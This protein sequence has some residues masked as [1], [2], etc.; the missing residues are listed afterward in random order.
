MPVAPVAADEDAG[1]VVDPP[2]AAAV[3]DLLVYVVVL[4]LFIEYAPQ[5]LSESF[6]LSLLT[7]VLLKVVLEAVVAVKDR[8]KGRLRRASTVPARVVAALGLWLLLAGSKFV[9]LGAVNLVFGDAVD[10]GGFVSVTLL[11]VVLML[12]RSGVRRLLSGLSPGGAPGGAAGGA[13]VADG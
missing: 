12:A 2:V 10:L 9:V 4:N 1:P 5:V 3:V 7:A 13:A 6:T 11:V 8:V